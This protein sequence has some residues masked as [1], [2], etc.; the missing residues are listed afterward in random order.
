MNRHQF[1]MN[2]GLNANHHESTNQ[3]RPINITDVFFFQY[4]SPTIM[5]NTLF[6]ATT[7]LDCSPTQQHCS[8]PTP[9]SL[10]ISC[11][12]YMNYKIHVL[13]FFSDVK[14]SEE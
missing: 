2:L 3:L 9:N 5:R 14:T 10:N 4:T 12:N 13:V 8:R 7:Q 6:T 11:N 1:K